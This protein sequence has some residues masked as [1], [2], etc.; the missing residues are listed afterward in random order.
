V[1]NL[2]QVVNH[3]AGLYAYIIYV[4]TYAHTYLRHAGAR[5]PGQPQEARVQG[6][7][8]RNPDAFAGGVSLTCVGASPELG[9]HLSCVCKHCIF[10]Y[11]ICMQ[12]C[13]DGMRAIF[14]K[15]IAFEFTRPDIEGGRRRRFAMPF[16]PNFT[17]LKMSKR[18]N[19]N[20]RRPAFL[21]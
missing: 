17:A 13:L 3:P 18:R 2:R 12:F 21:I 14:R 20:R 9:G 5:A 16:G 4:N 8:I 7:R 11:C 1:Y 10:S 6:L 19:C 15:R